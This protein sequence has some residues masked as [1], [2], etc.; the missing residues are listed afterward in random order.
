MSTIYAYSYPYGP[1]NALVTQGYFGSDLPA[2]LPTN[3]S[4]TLVVANPG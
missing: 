1:N 3:G 2:T 4:Y